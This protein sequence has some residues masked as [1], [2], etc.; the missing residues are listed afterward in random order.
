[1]L[2]KYNIRRSVY[3]DGAFEGNGCSRLLDE[4]AAGRIP[5]EQRA[6]PFV[7]ALKAFKAIASFRTA[8]EAT[9]LP[10]TLKVH[11]LCSHV[12]EYLE[13]YETVPDAGLGLSSEQSGESLHARLQRVWNL[14]FK[15]NPDNEVF[16]ERL[17]DCVVSYNWN[18]QWDEASR[19]STEGSE[20]KSSS[21]KASNNSSSGGSSSSRLPPVVDW[22]SASSNEDSSDVD[23][24]ESS[25]NTLD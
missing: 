18:L 8:W 9:S 19:V 13:R 24:Y 22:N 1:A 6:R 10:Y 5:F 21:E 14:R 7:E 2:V 11:V 20:S 23:S 25:S 4:I 15:A 3:F 16:R 17:V 12:E